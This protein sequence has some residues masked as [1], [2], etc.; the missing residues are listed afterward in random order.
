MDGRRGVHVP[1]GGLRRAGGAGDKWAQ[2]EPEERAAREGSGPGRGAGAQPEG[3]PGE[4]AQPSAPRARKQRAAPRKLRAPFPPSPRGPRELPAERADAPA[5]RG[6]GGAG[7]K[8]G[9]ASSGTH[10]DDQPRHLTRYSSLPCRERRG[11]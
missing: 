3:L 5:P 2:E 11:A 4:A 9:A 6:R 10:L 8:A 7:G 1:R